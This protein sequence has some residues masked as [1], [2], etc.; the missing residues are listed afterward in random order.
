MAASDY[1]KA[2]LRKSANVFVNG[3]LYSC[4]PSNVHRMT[5]AAEHESAAK[6]PTTPLFGGALHPFLAAHA[7]AAST[8]RWY[9]IVVSRRPWLRM[10]GRGSGNG[11]PRLPDAMA[12]PAIAPARSQASALDS[13]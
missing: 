8:P 1:F 7:V 10:T 5:G 6:Q 9:G 11:H 2:F 3:S 4:P 13:P 12:I